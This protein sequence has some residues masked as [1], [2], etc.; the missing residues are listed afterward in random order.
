MNTV[1]VFWNFSLG[2]RRCGWPFAYL[3]NC[4]CWS[5]FYMLQFVT[6]NINMF[7]KIFFLDQIFLGF[8]N[9][10][11]TIFL[12]IFA[13]DN[14]FANYP[15]GQHFERLLLFWTKSLPNV[16][17]EHLGVIFTNCRFTFAN[18]CSKLLFWIIFLCKLCLMRITFLQI[19]V[20]DS[21]FANS[22][23]GWFFVNF[24]HCLSGQI[25]WEFFKQLLCY[26]SSV[27]CPCGQI[28]FQNVPVHF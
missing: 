24:A 17:T 25:F 21:T 11:L 18:H 26:L 22:S 7:C 16:C 4:S 6:W 13:L 9:C 8:V 14:I 27:N 15:C 10:C 5:L 28:L 19:V 1:F 3:Q 2:N 12:Q 20:P 23:F